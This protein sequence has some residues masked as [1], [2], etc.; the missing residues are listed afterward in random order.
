[1]QYTLG[2]DKEKHLWSF[3]LE[4]SG[5]IKQQTEGRGMTSHCLLKME[6]KLLKI[7]YITQYHLA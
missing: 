4:V 1:M 7:S 5:S 6:S 3:R 2:H